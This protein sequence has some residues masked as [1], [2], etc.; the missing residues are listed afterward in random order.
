MIYLLAQF[1]TEIPEV[2]D[3]FQEQRDI[4]VGIREAVESVQFDLLRSPVYHWASL[5]GMFFYWGVFG[6]SG[7]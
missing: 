2:R 6:I 1:K 3:I 4:A 5:V 7:H